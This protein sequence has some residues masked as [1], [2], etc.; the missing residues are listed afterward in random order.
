VAAPVIAT[1]LPASGLVGAVE[2]GDLRRD[3]EVL[4]DAGTAVQKVVDAPEFASHD[5]SLSRS[6]A[7]T[8]GRKRSRSKDSGSHTEG[9]GP[10]FAAVPRRSRYELRLHGRRSVLLPGLARGA[11]STGE[12]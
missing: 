11:A 12:I 8:E 7:E 5:E 10:G 6:I 3:A 4:L 9:L 2:I 1:V